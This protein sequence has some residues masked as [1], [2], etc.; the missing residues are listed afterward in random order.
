LDREHLEK[1]AHNLN[2]DL[3]FLP[4]ITVE[5]ANRFNKFDAPYHFIEINRLASAYQQNKED[6]YYKSYFLDIRPQ[7]DNRP[8]PGRYLKWLRIRSLYRTLGSRLYA[9]LMSGEIVVSVVFFE[10]LAVSVFLLFL[11]LFFVR[12]CAKKPSLPQGL[13]FFAV[14]SG[15]MFIELFFIKE[16]ILLFGDP[17]VSFTVV[18]A[19][20]LIFSSFG[21]AWVQQKEKSIL[22]WMLPSLIAVLLLGAFTLDDLMTYLLRFPNIWRYA[23]ALL[24]LLPIGFLM[25]LPFPIGMRDLV[26]T[27]AQRA[28]AWSL[29]GCASI[30]T[31]IVSA[32]LAIIFGISL[33]WAC[34]IVA[35]LIVIISWRHM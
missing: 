31:S 21:G 8:F 22:K 29:N 26:G 18:V 4:G 23:G 2:F 28:Y 7:S 16:Y 14:G 25:G 3:V 1:F 11:P 27:S 17:V 12:R 34:A 33:L 6:A 5:Q 20:I 19:G 30:L 10:A 15:F 32:Q 9:L 13:Y 24:I 35:Y